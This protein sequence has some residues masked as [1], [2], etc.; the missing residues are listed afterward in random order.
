MIPSIKKIL[1]ATDLAPNSPFVFRY[2]MNSAIQHDAE[3]IIL[4]VFE[5]LSSANRAFLDLYLDEKQRKKIF[6]ERKASTL[7]RIRKRLRVFCEKELKN[8]PEQMKR[9][10]AIEACEGF[11]ADEILRRA[12]DLKCDVIVLGTHSK[13]FIENTF[14]GNTAK[15]VLRRTKI[16]VYIIPLS[17]RETRG[18]G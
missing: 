11:P 1:Y 18:N 14:L 5:E 15:R 10:S 7:K 17:G 2:A 12:E 3:I 13:G 9:I 16:P 8:D 6:K 4:H